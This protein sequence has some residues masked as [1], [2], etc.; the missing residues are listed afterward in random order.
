MYPSEAATAGHHPIILTF[1][2]GTHLLL[3]NAS[4]HRHNYHTKYHRWS[5]KAL[6]ISFPL[7]PV[8][9]HPLKSKVM[10]G[11]YSANLSDRPQYR[12]W[13]EHLKNHIF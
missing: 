11:D 7:I 5:S 9:A 10:D 1:G 6:E 4:E 3:E 12:A 8:C 2:G 13:A